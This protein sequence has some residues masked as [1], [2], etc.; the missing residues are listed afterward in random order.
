MPRDFRGKSYPENHKDLITIP[1]WDRYEKYHPTNPPNGIEYVPGYGFKRFHRLPLK[2]LLAYYI[3]KACNGNSGLE[4]D[5]IQKWSQKHGLPT[6]HPL[7]RCDKSGEWIANRFTVYTKNDKGNE[8][9][10][11]WGEK[12]INKDAFYCH[13]RGNRYDKS[14]Y[15]FI[16]LWNGSR[17][18]ECFKH[19]FHHWDGIWHSQSKEDHDLH[20]Q[21]QKQHAKEMGGI[22]RYHSVQPVW[23]NKRVTGGDVL[24]GV[25]LEVDARNGSSGRRLVCDEV[26]EIGFIGETDG[27]LNR[28]TG[29]E[30]VGQPLD[31]KTI[32]SEEGPWMKLLGRLDN[33]IVSEQ[34]HTYGMHISVS[35]GA[36]AEDHQIRFCCFIHHN[37]ELCEQ[38]GQRTYGYDPKRPMDESALS[39]QRSAAG[40]VGVHRIEVRLFKSVSKKE[41]FLRN[42][43]FTAAGVEFTRSEGPELTEKE[44]RN[45][46]PP[47]VQTYPNFCKFLGIS[48]SKPKKQKLI[49]AKVG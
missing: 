12:E 7:Y 11:N 39:V 41:D 18:S 8:V 16:E 13:H 44:F 46:L 10:Q 48:E 14:H 47:R 2:R 40:P 17:V 45:W 1:A 32:T 15:G 49:T 4:L 34:K 20:I 36:M 24:F 43:E 38:V 35:R 28:D 25:E 23:R 30:I 21:K 5:R 3:W 22:P 19:E 6:I 29:I 31:Y 33:K 27:S 9:T 42:V 37:K 26:D